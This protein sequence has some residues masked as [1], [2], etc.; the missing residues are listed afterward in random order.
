MREL[1]VRLEADRLRIQEALA[2]K[3]AEA[4]QLLIAERD[5]MMIIN[6][7]FSTLTSLSLLVTY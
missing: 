4:T 7:Q 3:H 1:S 6:S 5:R 2:Q